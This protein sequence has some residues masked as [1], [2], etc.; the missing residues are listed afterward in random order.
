M[1]PLIL[2]LLTLI[3]ALPAQKSN[4]DLDVINEKANNT[5]KAFSSNAKLEEIIKE[6]LKQRVVKQ[7]TIVLTLQDKNRFKRVEDKRYNLA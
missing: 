2:L 7:N 4:T 6:V 5:I 1:K 3:Y